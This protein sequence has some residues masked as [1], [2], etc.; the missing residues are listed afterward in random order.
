[1]SQAACRE[2]RECCLAGVDSEL[3]VSLWGPVQSENVDPLLKM[4][5]KV[6]LKV[7]MIYHVSL[8]WAG[9]RCRHQNSYEDLAELHT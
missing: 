6:P 1:M 7:H 9:F 3:L 2:Q 5:D 4:Q 8:Y